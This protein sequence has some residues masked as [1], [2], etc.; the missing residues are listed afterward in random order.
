MLTRSQDF[1]QALVVNYRSLRGAKLA[2][3]RSLGAIKQA[4]YC[5]LEKK[6]L[7]L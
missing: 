1:E 6:V 7:T 4:D 5:I 3:Y 2:N